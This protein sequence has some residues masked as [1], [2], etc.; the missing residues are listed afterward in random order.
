MKK[1]YHKEKDIAFWVSVLV[2]I[3]FIYALYN[4]FLL[5]KID[6]AQAFLEAMVISTTLVTMVALYL[7]GRIWK[8]ELK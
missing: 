2:Y 7:Y 3:C 6:W 8:K 5:A 4:I 1:S